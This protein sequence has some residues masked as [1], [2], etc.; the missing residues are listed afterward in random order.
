MTGQEDLGNIKINDDVVA[1]IASLALVDVEGVVSISGKSSYSDYVGSKSK[2]SDKGVAVK[3][4]EA[5]NLC[6]VNV[7]IHI[8]YGAIIYDTAR[9]LQRT[10]KNAIENLTGL[11][12]DKVNVTIR[13]LVVHE[14]PR[15]S[16]RSK[17]A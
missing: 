8:E 14:Q 4:D 7:E 16:T 6:T 12:V 1:L 3:I 15:S 13:G 2:D 5:T 10:I 11:T 17:T 9:K